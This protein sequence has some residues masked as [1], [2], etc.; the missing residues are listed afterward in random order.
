MGKAYFCTACKRVFSKDN[1]CTCEGEGCIKEMKLGTPVNV[2]GTKL[3]GKIYKIKNDG[4]EVLITS[5]PNKHIKEY[6]LEE[7]RK[8]L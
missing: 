3:K 8:V 7:V 6:K 5:S 4:V 1:G 2:I